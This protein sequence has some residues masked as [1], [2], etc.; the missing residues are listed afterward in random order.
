MISKTTIKE[1]L[2]KK[3]NPAIVETLS[4]LRKQKNPF[5]LKVAGLISKPKRRG[6]IVNL[7]KIEKHAKEGETIVVPGK[8]LSSGELK[9]K[10][11]LAAVSS[12]AGTKDKV[13]ITSIDDLVK[14][15]PKGEGIRIIM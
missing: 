12:S 10:I 11:I 13:K 1:R 2:R 5:W 9:K 15:N 7:S 6:I 8:I 14:K 3:T 4:L